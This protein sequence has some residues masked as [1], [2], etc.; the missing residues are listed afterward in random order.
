MS[1]SFEYSSRDSIHAIV[2]LSK[3]TMDEDRELLYQAEFSKLKN[4]LLFPSKKNSKTI[5]YMKYVE[6]EKVT[7]ITKPHA[8]IPFTCYSQYSKY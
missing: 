4:F 3:K 5:R 8:V 6:M 1:I 2:T 7:T